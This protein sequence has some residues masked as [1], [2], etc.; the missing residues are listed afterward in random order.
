M[1][2][3]GLYRHGWRSAV[4]RAQSEVFLS[5]F[6]WFHTG[7]ET[8]G[9]GQLCT[10]SA[11]AAHVCFPGVGSDQ[12]HTHG[13]VPVPGIALREALPLRLLG[14]CLKCN[15]DQEVLSKCWWWLALCFQGSCSPNVL[16]NWQIWVYLGEMVD[17]VETVLE[18]LFYDSP[19]DNTFIQ[20]ILSITIF[21]IPH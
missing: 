14:S 13:A 9:P 11:A 19:G 8:V 6:Q 18:C 2:I 10:H 12:L 20:R 15:S 5:G 21:Q 1:G 3:L 7:R 16:F 17:E 4:R